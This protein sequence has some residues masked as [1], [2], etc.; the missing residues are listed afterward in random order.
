MNARLPVVLALTLVVGVAIGFALRPNLP[1]APHGDAAGHPAAA[2]TATAADAPPD[3]A[4]T[5]PPPA[6]DPEAVIYD[7]PHLLDTAL[8][9]LR[10]RTPGKINLYVVA[11]AGDG[12][13]DVFR[14]EAEYVEQ[15][16]SQ[17]FGAAGHVVVLENNPATVHARPLATLTNLVWT[18]D[19]IAAQMDPEQDVLLLYLTTHGSED[20][21]LLVDLD[22]LP[23]NQISPQDLADALDTT[24][25]I[26]SRVVI[27][28]ACYSGG[29]IDALR[30]DSTLVITSARADRTSFGCGVE[31]DITYFGNAF[32]V[33]ALNRTTSFTQAFT[34]AARTVAEWE[35]DDDEEHS[36]PQ[37]A[38]A[39]P[40][41]A[42]LA[43]WAAQLAPAPPVP[44]RPVGASGEAA[45]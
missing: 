12:S 42:T 13:E 7:Q 36:E 5:A 20:H 11:F 44:F 21:E 25:A 8:L 4:G 32:L 30:N 41:E 16:F 3:D 6:F 38:S 27:V 23:L 33:E 40:I 2:S 34:D 45:H 28:N 18:L 24:P 9:A 10:P 29:F 43:R 19:E 37:I 14:N 35:T 15:L 26:R 22:P 1:P 39:A 31:S 17:R